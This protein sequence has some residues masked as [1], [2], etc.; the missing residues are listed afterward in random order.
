MIILLRVEKT[1]MFYS[2]SQFYF[3]PKMIVASTSLGFDDYHL[4][5]AK[6]SL[7]KKTCPVR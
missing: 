5:P 2:F 4:K 3:F 1:G 7:K 6:I